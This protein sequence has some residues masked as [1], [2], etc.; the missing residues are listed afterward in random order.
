MVQTD[1]RQTTDGRTTTYSER[2]RSLKTVLVNQFSTLASH[3]Q[4][5]NVRIRANACFT[6]T[7]AKNSHF[8]LF[9]VGRNQPIIAQSWLYLRSILV[10]I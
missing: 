3:S 9:T 5:L 1:R 7:H 8:V 10:N 4:D 2:E 6:R